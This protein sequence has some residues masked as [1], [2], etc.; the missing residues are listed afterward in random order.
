MTY[1]G[2]AHKNLLEGFFSGLTVS[3]WPPWKLSNPGLVTHGGIEP[4]DP[5]LK[6]RW[7][8]RLPNAPCG[9]QN[10]V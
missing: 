6:A 4:T 9:G 7:L 3:Q 2:H 8:N 10:G 1:L 5:G